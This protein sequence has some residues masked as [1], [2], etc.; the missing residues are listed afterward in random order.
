MTGEASRPAPKRLFHVPD[1]SSDREDEGEQFTESPKEMFLDAV[2]TAQG[3]IAN[4]ESSEDSSSLTERSKDDVRR[5]HVLMELLTT[6]V[7]YLMDLREMVNVSYLSPHPCSVSLLLLFRVI[8]A[9]SQ[10]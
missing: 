3:S 6:E 8:F 5:Y 1:G 4:G 7:G 9:N 2:M 10:R